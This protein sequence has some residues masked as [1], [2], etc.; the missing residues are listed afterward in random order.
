MEKPT[1]SG[2]VSRAAIGVIQTLIIIGPVVVT[3]AVFRIN[4]KRT[5]GRDVV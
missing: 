5:I 1:P 3:R 2:R 4:L